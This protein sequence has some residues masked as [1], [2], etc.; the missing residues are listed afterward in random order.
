MVGTECESRVNSHPVRGSPPLTGCEA[1][2]R[3]CVRGMEIFGPAV[4]VYHQ[5]L[6][7]RGS[8]KEWY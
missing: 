3:A 4:V 6:G 1:V 5:V 8:L 2:S 7:F